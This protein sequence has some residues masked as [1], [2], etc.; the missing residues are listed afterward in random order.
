MEKQII[1]AS[2]YKVVRKIG[3]GGMAKVYLA[4]DTKDEKNVALKVLKK[5]NIEAKKIRHLK[6]E[7]NVLKLLDDDNIVKTYDIGSENNIYYI[8]N[9]FVDGMTLKEYIS[10]CSPIPIEEVIL[11]GKQILSGLQHAH[12]KNVVHKDIKS[13]NILIDENK[14]IKITDFGTADIL[15]EDIT[16]TQSLMGTPQYIAPE[17]LNRD[18]LTN[19]SDI[20][21]V[22]ILMYE[23]LVGK[24]PFTGEKPAVIMVKQLNHPTPSIVIQRDD[25]PQSV[26]NVIIKATAKKLDNRYLT[27]EE[28]LADLRTVLDIENLNEDK[29]VLQNDILSEEKLEQTVILD[30]NFN[31][32]DL[33]DISKKEK[34]K[35]NRYRIAA[36]GIGLIIILAL[37]FIIIFSNP[38]MLMPE[39]VGEKKDVASN[40]IELL[41]YD[42]DDVTVVFEDSEEIGKDTI[43]E[44]DPP[45]GEAIT[46]DTKFVITISTG[47]A[48]STM[49]DYT[50]QSANG[51][52]SL[53]EDQGFE[54]TIREV[55][56]SEPAGTIVSQTPTVGTK[57]T[58]EDQISFDVSTGIY[59]IEIPNFTNLELDEVTEWTKEN[60]MQLT[61]T[62]EC[63]D[64]YEKGRVISQKPS[65]GTEIESGSEIEVNISDGS[66]PVVENNN[67]D[68][69]EDNT[70]NN[71]TTNA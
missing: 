47:P 30:D 59:Q 12:S 25:V 55:E 54:V 6:K 36:V 22:G 28:M 18:P 10:T 34:T 17:I 21:S 1:I 58:T 19:Q 35:K 64:T 5:E 41:G 42:E 71:G 13:Q 46:P 9:E 69:K 16:R 20:Y 44:T 29:F 27:A 31:Y 65:Y 15:D 8:S 24:A 14:Q 39:L 52:V 51:V 68:E 7:A 66:C 32:K 45:A 56:S 60:D 3:E 67:L 23:L 2:R 38:T 50:F 53:L 43:I 33:K 11:I 63:N 62:Y 61:T 70:N 26:E 40:Q 49:L 4:Y 57:I 37:I 48:E